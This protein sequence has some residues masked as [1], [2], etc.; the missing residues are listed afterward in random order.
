MT[1]ALANAIAANR[2]GF[3]GEMTQEN[4]PTG[5]VQIESFLPRDAEI[6]QFFVGPVVE[7]NA[8]YIVIDVWG[9]PMTF[10]RD[11]V[12]VTPAL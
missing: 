2:C 1:T 11:R 4:L 5:W 6:A 7:D 10:S 3:T 9:K 8:D 12:I